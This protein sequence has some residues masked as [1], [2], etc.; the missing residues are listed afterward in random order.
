MIETGTDDADKASLLAELCGYA[1]P[2]RII[3]RPSS[4]RQ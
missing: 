4:A 3:Q 1:A 2:E